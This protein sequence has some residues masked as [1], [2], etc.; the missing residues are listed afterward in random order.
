MKKL[1]ITSTICFAFGWVVGGLM[2]HLADEK[3]FQRRTLTGVS[4]DCYDKQG[5]L[6]RTPI[7]KN[8]FDW[9]KYPKMACEPGPDGQASS[10]PTT[11]KN[12]AAVSASVVLEQPSFAVTINL[13]TIR[14]VGR[15]VIEILT[16]DEVAA[17][18]K[19]SKFHVYEFGEAL[20]QIR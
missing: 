4:V 9:D 6:I 17:L 8:G 7:E 11:R 1:L 5:N 14:K 3:D 13:E 10:G 20:H 16:A 15:V 2:Q 12:L 19:V 18:L